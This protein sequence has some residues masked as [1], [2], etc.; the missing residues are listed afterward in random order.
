MILSEFSLKRPV[1]MIMIFIAVT[2]LGIISLLNLKLDLMPNVDIPIVAVM[3]EYSGVGPAEVE[4]TVSRT[5]EGAVSQVQDIKNVYSISRE[6]TSMII[7]EFNW[8]TDV[9]KRAMDT[10]EKLDMVKRYLPVDVKSP[11]VFKF[12]PSMIPVLILGV[13]SEQRDL[14]G[15]REFAEDNIKDQLAQ[16][17]GVALVQVSGGRQRE[18]HV[19]VDHNRLESVGMPLDQVMMALRMANMNVP[20]GH[21]KAGVMDFLIRTPG[22]FKTVEEIGQTVVGNKGGVQIFLRDVAR[23]ADSFTDKDSEVKMNGRPAVVLLIQKQSSANTVQVSDRVLK[24]IAELQKTLPGDVKIVVSMDTADFIRK[25]IANLTSEAAVGALLAVIVI[26]FFLYSVSSTLIIAIAI[27]FSVIA[28]FILMY[29]NN[30]TLNIITLGGLSLGI[31]RLVDDSIVVLENIFR[32]RE[33]G[34][35]AKQAALQG[36]DEVALAV[37]ATTVTT[38]VVFMPIAFVSGMAGVMFKPMALTVGFALIASYFIAMMLV[39]LLT[40]RFMK[41]EHDRLE[42]QDIFHRSLAR[43]DRFMRG[44]SDRYQMVVHWAIHHRKAVI[45]SVSAAGLLTLSL[46]WPFKFIG[47]EFIPKSDSGELEIAVKMPVGT[48]FQ[49]TSLVMNKIDSLLRA[50]V[51]EALSIYTSFGEKEGIQAVI[52]SG[53]HLGTI[54][55]RLAPRAER[56]RSAETISN[57]LIA[58][59]SDNPDANIVISAGGMMGGMMGGSMV[60]RLTGSSGELAV[61]ISGYDLQASEKLAKQIKGLMA[62]IPGTKSVNTSLQ[63]GY[64]ELQVQVDREK[65]GS[66]GLSVYQVAATVETAFKGKTATRFRDAVR[67]KEYDVVVRLAKEDRRDQSSLS[68]LTVASPMGQN[69]VLANVARVKKAFGPVDIIRKN[70]Q[71]IA[72]VSCDI[73]GRPLN[74]A[75]NE[76]VAKLREVTIP[77]GFTLTVGGSAKEMSESF[78][79]LFFAAHLALLLVYM[80]LAAQFESLLDPFIV[81][82]SVPLGILGVIWGLF[83]AG[84]NLSV[85]AFLGI[86]MMIGIVVSNAILLVDCAN[87]LRRRGVELYEAVVLAGR[88]RFRP[89]L[90]TSVVT[91][92]AMIPMALGMGESGEMMAPMA[93]SVISGLAVSMVLTLLLVPTLYVIFEERFKREIAVE[94]PLRRADDP[95]PNRRATDLKPGA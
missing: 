51:P 55:I 39:P 41:V 43:F 3:T 66:L 76:L 6:G 95:H 87:Q 19:E 13:S 17:E 65:A 62:S 42:R 4:A 26:I 37:L 46:L 7:G 75:T 58:K 64:P 8:G 79:S 73:S 27:P 30:M 21:L 1:A 10:R 31:G 57:S 69:V 48:S 52:G 53:P 54:R 29:F 80:I 82:F 22:E 16:V 90:M 33:Q 86:I 71:R 9:D 18:I 78:N 74:L 35:E 56:K 45:L 47:S 61:E 88:T 24:K 23:V 44:L 15:L 81:M 59:L 92:L 84:M 85:V 28:T 72:T 68:R 63:S 34:V 38:I 83:L 49:Q 5:L 36:S 70:Q 94:R 2:V 40:T 25:A 32:H 14:R 91:I 89:I 60:G 77:P 12:D 20:G 93:V 11:T 50:D 67:G